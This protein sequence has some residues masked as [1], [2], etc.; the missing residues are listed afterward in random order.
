M[1]LM[2]SA[3]FVSCSMA[4]NGVAF[5]CQK[6]LHAYSLKEQGLLLEDLK[7]SCQSSRAASGAQEQLHA[8]PTTRTLPISKSGAKFLAGER[9]TERVRLHVVLRNHNSELQEDD[10]IVDL[11]AAWRDLVGWH[12]WCGN[13]MGWHSWNLDAEGKGPAW[14]SAPKTTKY[15]PL[16]PSGFLLL[17]V[18]HTCST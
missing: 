12:G 5:L 9:G 2:S 15:P 4:F 7:K 16:C 8:H 3:P 11:S 14:Y 10:E 13:G 18:D 17:L 6:Q 1:V